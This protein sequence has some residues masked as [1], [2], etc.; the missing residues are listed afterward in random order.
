MR[1]PGLVYIRTSSSPIGS[2]L[3]PRLRLSAALIRGELVS[4]D[5]EELRRLKQEVRAAIK[6]RMDM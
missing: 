5:A 1:S 2:C 3:P 4:D 6:A